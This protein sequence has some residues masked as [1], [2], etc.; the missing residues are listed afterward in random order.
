MRPSSY[1][2]LPALSAVLAAQSPAQDNAMDELMALLN[3]PVTVASKTAMTTRESP[4]IVTLIRRDEILATGARDLMELLRLVPGFSFAGDIQSVVGV[5]VRGNW[6]H[7]GK[8][9]LLWDG[10]EMNETRYATLQF[11]N[12]FPVEQIQQIEIIRGPG[13]AIY[14]GFAEL[15]VINV[16]TRSGADLKGVSGSLGASHASKDFTRRTANVAYGNVWGD[17]SLSASYFGGTGNRS[18][19]AYYDANTGTS[20]SL[21]DHAANDPSLFNLGASW[22]GLSLRF[23]RDQYESTDFDV[24]AA[25]FPT[26]YDT[27]QFGGTYAEVKYQWKVLDQLT[28]TPKFS[29]KEQTPWRYDGDGSAYR[30][31]SRQVA[32]LQASWDATSRLNLI[33]GV[34]LTTDK[35]TNPSGDLFNYNQSDHLTFDS[36]AFYVQA[37]WKL[38]DFNL[39]GGARFD[40]H[41]V[42]GSSFVP[43]FAITHAGPKFHFKFL[44]SMAFRAPVQENINL[45][46]EIKP[47][48]TTGL[49]L[50]IGAQLSGNAYASFNLFNISIKDPISYYNPSPGEDGYKNFEKTGT[51]GAELDLQVRGGWG[52]VHT[53]LSYSQ[54]ADN[55]VPFYA[56]PQTDRYMTG[57]PNLK[58]ALNASFDLGQGLR[59]TPSVVALGPRYGVTPGAASPQEMPSVAIFNLWGA[60]KRGDWDLSLGLLNVTGTQ[61]DIPQGYHTQDGGG[62]PPIP[63]QGREVALR[64]GYRL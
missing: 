43:R 23:I 32:G 25:F 55:Q 58:L 27:I 39:T 18:E 51:R 26:P 33:A 48:K 8:V 62:N 14:G 4:G 40:K 35:G 30:K 41:E 16:V 47:E 22:R 29:W 21:R 9:L 42:F 1:W 15:A 7:E 61:F 53:S 36:Q 49:E 63:G 5:G 6:G 54:A 10:Q 13:S 57:M 2:M 34:D 56:V 11:G 12:H 59:F 24:N 52:F 45:R 38:Q 44:A 3:T 28:L 31:V 50:E 64:V 19:G 37:L 17:F 60:W 46:P 20:A